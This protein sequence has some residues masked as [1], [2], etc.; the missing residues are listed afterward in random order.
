M[1]DITKCKGT[2]CPKREGCYRFTATE[3][4]RQSYF[5]DVPYQSYGLC[6]WFWDNKG[7]AAKL[8]AADPDN[9]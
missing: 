5:A 4:E 3:G 9:F 7:R 1:A 8:D 6:T 2:D